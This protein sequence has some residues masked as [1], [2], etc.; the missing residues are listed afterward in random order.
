MNEQNTHEQ[1]QQSQPTVQVSKG[2]P[3]L[4]K[5]NFLFVNTD[6]KEELK[7][8]SIALCRCGGSNNKPCCD[9]THRK[10]GFDKD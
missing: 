1:T 5:G 6:G 3:Y 8:G 10:I 7:E 4:V 9:G 2:G